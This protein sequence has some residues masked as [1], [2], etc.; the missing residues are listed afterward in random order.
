M[1]REFRLRKTKD[2]QRLRS[3]GK[4]YSNRLLVLLVKK[5][6]FDGETFQDEY[7]C[8]VGVITGK[9][10]G[11]AVTRN[12]VKRRIH[13]VLT[14]HYAELPDQWDFLILARKPIVEASYKEIE[15][16]VLSLLRRAEFLDGKNV[17][18]RKTR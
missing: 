17:Q 10:I 11:N 15:L 12:K 9:R 8:R 6:P 13:A 14:Q 1:K 3:E 2:I 16:A 7:P 5:Q 4:A 18:P